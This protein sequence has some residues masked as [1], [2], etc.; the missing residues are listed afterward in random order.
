[1]VGG[2]MLV[3][4]IAVE[5]GRFGDGGHSKSRNC[6]LQTLALRTSHAC[7]FFPFGIAIAEV[8][9]SN[10]G[11]PAVVECCSVQAGFQHGHSLLIKRASVLKQLQTFVFRKN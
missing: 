1:M 4:N 5:R 7:C 2:V 3:L 11:I 9:A 10:S 8:T 6:C